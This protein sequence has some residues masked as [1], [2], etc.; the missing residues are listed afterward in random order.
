MI[1]ALKAAIAH[2]THDSGWGVVRP[3]LTPLT[4]EQAQALAADLEQKG[5]VMPG[6]AQ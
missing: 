2:Y 5:F 1:P 3:P 4:A 6:I